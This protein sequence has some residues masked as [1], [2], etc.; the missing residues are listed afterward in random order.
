MSYIPLIKAVK[1]VTVDLKDERGDWSRGWVVMDD[2]AS[3]RP[4]AE[5]HRHSQDYKKTR[6]AS[7][8]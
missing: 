7:D 8:V 6:K 1:G 5:V 4:F 3:P 2:P